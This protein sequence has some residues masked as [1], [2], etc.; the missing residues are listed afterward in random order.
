MRSILARAWPVMLAVALGLAASQSL[1]IVGRP[2]T[3]LEPGFV[4]R[5]LGS[6][7]AIGVAGWLLTIAAAS[8][9]RAERF[10]VR[11]P[12]IALWAA[13]AAVAASA[14]W[15]LSP[16]LTPLV[17]VVVLWLMPGAAQ[18][19]TLRTGL[20][21][22]RRHPVRLIGAVVVTLVLSVVAWVAGL[23]FGFF[24]TG[25]LGTFLAWLVAGLLASVVIAMWTALRDRAAHPVNPQPAG[26]AGA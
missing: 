25:P 8:A 19:R 11:S 13:V 3:A 20:E 7:A 2:P 24:V 16:F 15:V 21:V 17:L 5:V 12:G 6:I 1:L 10:R 4:L 9:A 26:V 18:V 14:A 22:A 23:V